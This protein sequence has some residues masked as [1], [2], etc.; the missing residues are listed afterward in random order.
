[1]KKRFAAV[2]V[3]GL[4]GL[5]GHAHAADWQSG[6]NG[7]SAWAMISGSKAGLRLSCNRGQRDLTFVLTGGPFPGMKNVDDGKESMMMWIEMPDGRTGRHP[8]DGH[9]F[10]PDR[11]FIGR[12]V[13]SNTVLDQF[14]S[15]SKLSLTAPTGAGIAAFGMTGTGKARG[16]FKQACR[17]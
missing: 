7:Q 1:M 5:A 15:G 11:A 2:L 13:V 4:A 10:A 14:R 8:I 3:L 9:Y 17:L 6:E 12:F 16:H